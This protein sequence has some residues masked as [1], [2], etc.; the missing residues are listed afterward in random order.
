MSNTEERDILIGRA[1][2]LDLRELL[3]QVLYE[4]YIPGVDDVVLWERV[5]GLIR[6]TI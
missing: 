6:K 4:S 2:N 1:K 3:H 5:D